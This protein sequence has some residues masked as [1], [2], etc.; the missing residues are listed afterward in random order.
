MRRS[1][2][3]SDE[4]FSK[5]PIETIPSLEQARSNMIHSGLFFE[6][7]PARIMP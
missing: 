7:K 6:I 2:R 4:L 5:R 1:E 3:E